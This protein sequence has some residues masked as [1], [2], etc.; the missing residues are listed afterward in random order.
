MK[1]T[2]RTSEKRPIRGDMAMTSNINRT[3]KA[4]AS[5]RKRL[6]EKTGTR[7]GPSRARK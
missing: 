4:T 1:K 7:Q 2:F 6:G 3:H 5:A